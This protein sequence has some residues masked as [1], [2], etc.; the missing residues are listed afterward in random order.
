MDGVGCVTM[1]AVDKGIGGIEELEI[2]S[3]VG[4][5]RPREDP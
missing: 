2:A 1:V 5:G 3:M 4:V